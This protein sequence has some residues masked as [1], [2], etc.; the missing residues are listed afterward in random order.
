MHLEKKKLTTSNTDEEIG[1]HVCQCGVQALPKWF[2][3]ELSVGTKKLRLELVLSS[4]TKFTFL[5]LLLCANR[6]PVMGCSMA[7]TARGSTLLG[8]K[9]QC[10]M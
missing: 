2:C 7:E 9:G 10:Y 5:C 6:T 3:M 4:G 8:L 1:E